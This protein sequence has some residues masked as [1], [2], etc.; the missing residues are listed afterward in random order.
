VPTGIKSENLNLLEPSRPVMGLL[1][2]YI[3][4]EMWSVERNCKVLFVADGIMCL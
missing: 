3:S 4:I 2:L 1:Y